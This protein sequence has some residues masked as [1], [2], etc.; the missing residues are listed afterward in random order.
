MSDVIDLGS[1]R[2]RQQVDD[3]QAL[4]IAV[5]AIRKG[6]YTDDDL[7]VAGITREQAEEY[8][9]RDVIARL[10][11]SY[12]EATLRAALALKTRER[13]DPH[14]NGYLDEAWPNRPA[15]WS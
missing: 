8:L 14:L 3:D 1:F 9:R 15:V 2:E 7:R 12:D 6:Y 10:A 4:D 13:H 5:N 11:R